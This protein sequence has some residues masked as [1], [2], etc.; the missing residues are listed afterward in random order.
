MKNLPNKFTTIFSIIILLLFSLYSC[1][2]NQKGNEEKDKLNNTLTSASFNGSDTIVRFSEDSVGIGYIHNG[3]FYL[4]NLDTSKYIYT[5]DNVNYTMSNFRIESSKGIYDLVMFGSGQNGEHILLGFSCFIDV[6]N[7]VNPSAPLGGIVKNS[8]KGVCCSSCTFT[9]NN[10]GAVDGC[11]CG[12]AGT[13]CG[14]GV[15]PHCDHSITE[16]GT[17]VSY[18]DYISNYNEYPPYDTY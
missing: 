18:E 17:K 11:T 14:E 2:T 9:R 6:P 15:S 13:G 8:C 5:Q 12:R 4:N 10:L 3:A 1:E 7:Y 16:A